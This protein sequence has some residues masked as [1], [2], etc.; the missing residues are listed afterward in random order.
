MHLR[1]T[2]SRIRTTA[3]PHGGDRRCH[4]ASAIGAAVVTAGAAEATGGTAA[5]GAMD[6][7]AVGAVMAV[8]MGADTRAVVWAAVITGAVAEAMD[9][10]IE[11]QARCARAAASLT[12]ETM[13]NHRKRQTRDLNHNDDKDARPGDGANTSGSPVPDSTAPVLQ[14]EDDDALVDEDAPGRGVAPK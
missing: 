5:I 10:R 3:G 2:P 11:R 12:E 4:W 7:G 1:I 6:I 9:V 13:T 8:G 14:S